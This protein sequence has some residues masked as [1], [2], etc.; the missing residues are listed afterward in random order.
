MKTITIISQKGG[1]G[2]S[3]T[4]HAFGAWLT[5][6]GRRVLF[7]EL[8]AQGNLTLAGGADAGGLASLDGISL[9]KTAREAARPVGPGRGNLIPGSPGLA[10]ADMAITATGKEYRLREALEAVKGDYD[11]CIVDTPPALGILTV[12]ALTACQEAIIPAQ[13]DIFSLQGIAHLHGTIEA[14]RQYCNPGLAVKGIVLTR[15][16]PRAVISRDVADLIEQ[17]AGQLGTRLYKVAIRECLALKEAQVQR[18]DIFTYAPKSN[19]AAD[20]AAFGAETLG[21]EAAAQ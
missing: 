12:N 14:V 5:L 16:N 19:A 17:T 18:Q 4:A 10:G 7:V 3:T 9:A 2:K 11:Y 8:D 1:V 15:H 20:Y 21:E 6:R 13:A